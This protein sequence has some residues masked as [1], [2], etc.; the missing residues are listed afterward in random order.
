M[1]SFKPDSRP[2]VGSLPANRPNAGTG[3][4]PNIA[5]RPNVG[6]RPSTLPA[7]GIG[8]GVAAGGGH[9]NRLP[10]LDGGGDRWQQVKSD[11]GNWL[12]DSH[13]DLQGRLSG[14]QDAIGDWQNNR[15]DFLNNRREDWQS[16][17]DNRYPYHDGWHHGYWH[18]G[19]GSYWEHM[20][21]EHP[22]WAAWGMTNWAWNSASYL[23][24]LGSYYNPYYVP[25]STGVYDYS[26][27]I[28]TYDQS[29]APAAP[30]DAALPPG[31]S[32]AGLDAFNQAREL[33]KQGDY[34]NALGQADTALKSMPGDAL[35]HEFRALCLFALGDY[36]QAAATLNAVLSVGPGWDWTT[37]SSLYPSVDTYTAQ[38]RKLEDY[39]SAHPKSADARFVLGYHYLTMGNKD[40]AGQQFAKVAELQPKDAVAKQLAEMLTYKAPDDAPPKIKPEAALPGPKLAADDLIGDW[41][42]AGPGG[43]S[44]GL[45][46]TKEN[47]FTWKYTKGKKEQTVKG[48]FAVDGNTL[49]MEPEEGGVML[50]DLTSFGKT[51]FNF[52]MVGDKDSAPPL[53]FTR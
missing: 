48:A 40:I 3:D 28:V 24:G 43:S 29:V 36:P 12:A 17:L 16:Q 34:K 41:K 52:K 8:A 32:K 23:F 9:G 5:D 2:S 18:G 49:A 37:M 20:W 6:N 35:I 53:K 22:V 44:F 51:G 10:G 25:A 50:A 30:A 19:A 39:V 11:R 47:E 26:Q 31:V 42:A 45:S 14:R 46:L 15:Q 4:R 27:P 1:P 33:F 21:A 38:L 7:V 13:Q